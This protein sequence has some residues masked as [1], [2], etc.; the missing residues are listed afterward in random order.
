MK[1]KIAVLTGAGV[2]AES[3]ISTF[4]DSG[5]LWE[6]YN[7]EDVASIEGWRRHPGLVLDFYNARRKQ[8]AS[9]R[10]N[11]AHLAIAGL[12]KDHEVT[13][14]TQNVD[15]LHERAGST[16][17]IHLHGELTKVRPEDCCNEADGYSEAGVF[18]IGY[19]EIHLGDTGPDGAR[20]RPHIVWFGE[21]VPKISRAI[22]VVEKADILLIVGTSL[23]VYPAAGLYRYA[24]I[25]TPIYIIDPKDVPV[26]DN[27]IVHIREVATRGMEKFVGIISGK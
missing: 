13:V 12:E 23:Q 1:K 3:G 11:A 5:G 7:V 15:N 21:A 9:A 26:H 18:D 16:R 25:R 24:G 8:L 20:L 22:E 17:I 4:R 19:G 6:N 2:S 10:P 27:R 14:I